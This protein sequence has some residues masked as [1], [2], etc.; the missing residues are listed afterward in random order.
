LKKK[1]I[2]PVIYNGAFSAYN[3]SLELIKLVRDVVPMKPDVVISYGGIGDFAFVLS[4]KHKNLHKRPF[5]HYSLDSFFNWLSQIDS[6]PV[7][8]GLQND[9]TIDVFWI[10]N[11]R[12]MNSISMEFGIKFLGVLQA[13][14][15]SEGMA[16]VYMDSILKSKLATFLSMADEMY[17]NNC[18]FKHIYDNVESR[19]ADIPY[20][21][22]FRN[23]FDNT[24]DVYFDSAHAQER[25]NEVIAMH[26]FKTLEEMGYLGKEHV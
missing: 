5:V 14:A 15:F 24:N 20:I 18:N 19:I 3:S 25:G 1:G 23:I 6:L 2:E 13:S 21:R 12:M 9:K 22:S 7:S 10:D 11:M 17:R 4:E 26:M 16:S 8:F